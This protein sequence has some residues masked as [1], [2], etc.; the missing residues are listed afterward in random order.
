MKKLKDV[1]SSMAN[2]LNAFAH[3]PELPDDVV[4][5][6]MDLQMRISKLLDKLLC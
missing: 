1:L 5:D 4:S 6:L 3:N 2:T